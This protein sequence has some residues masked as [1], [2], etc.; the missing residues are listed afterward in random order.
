MC[1]HHGK[2]DSSSSLC[3]SIS[4]FAQGN[5]NHHMTKINY[6]AFFSLLTQSLTP[7][8]LPFHAHFSPLPNPFCPLFLP[9]SLLPCPFLPSPSCPLSVPHSLLPSLSSFSLTPFSLPR[10][11]LPFLPSSLPLFPA[12]SI[13]SSHW[14]SGKVPTL[15]VCIS[16]IL[17]YCGGRDITHDRKNML[18]YCRWHVITLLPRITNCPMYKY[19]TCVILLDSSTDLY[20]LATTDL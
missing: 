2:V 4:P 10:P 8:S 6:K 3:Y 18:K 13:L 9:L 5:L 17:K 11:L 19:R 14:E 1:V 7:P 15:S 20:T 12:F 16:S